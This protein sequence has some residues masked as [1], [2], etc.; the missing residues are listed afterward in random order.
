LDVSDSGGVQLEVCDAV[1][2]LQ[3]AMRS[4]VK[5]SSHLEPSD[6]AQLCRMSAELEALVKSCDERRPMQRDATPSVLVRQLSRSNVK[7]RGAVTRDEE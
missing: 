4:L 2:T 3:D 5:H 6:V 1:S 7:L